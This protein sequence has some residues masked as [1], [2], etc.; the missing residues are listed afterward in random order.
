MQ[1]ITTTY[2]ACWWAGGSDKAGYTATLVACGWA[3]AVM[4]KNNQAVGQEQ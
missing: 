1:K 3:W 2:V 4:K